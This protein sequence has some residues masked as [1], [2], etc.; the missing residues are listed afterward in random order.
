MEAFNIIRDRELK[1][2]REED[3]QISLVEVDGETLYDLPVPLPPSPDKDA[4]GKPGN[5]GLIKDRSPPDPVT[6][7]P[8]PGFAGDGAADLLKY[9][10]DISGPDRDCRFN[11]RR[12]W[13]QVRQECREAGIPRVE[14]RQRGRDVYKACLISECGPMLDCEDRCIAH[15]KRLLGRCLENGGELEQCRED[16][17]AA[18]EAPSPQNQDTQ[19]MLISEARLATTRVASS[20]SSATSFTDASRNPRTP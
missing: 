9:S 19:I 6:L 13:R 11:C 1:H 2:P 3:Q 20:R 14:C 16:S 10:A 8:T 18:I 15:G 5:K 17:D 7:A 4:D 12:R